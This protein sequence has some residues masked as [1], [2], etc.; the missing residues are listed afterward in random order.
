MKPLHFITC[1]ILFIT[2]YPLTAQSE[3]PD[4]AVLEGNWKLDMSPENTS[5]TNF[6]K[7]VITSADGNEIQGT[8]YR[9]GV[10]I[11]EGRINTQTGVIYGALV[12]GD[13]SG[14][15]NTSFYYKDGKLYGTTHSLSRNF[16]SVWTA[17]KV[18]K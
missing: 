9:D 16:L 18:S 2:M 15:Y 11:Q 6:A 3:A 7:M 1:L 17:T 8:F 5:D 14:T 4:T 13:N 10:A 12:S